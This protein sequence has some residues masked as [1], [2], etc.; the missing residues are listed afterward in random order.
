V[1]SGTPGPVVAKLNAEIVRL[2]K[3]QEVSERL[4]AVQAADPHGTTPGEFQRFVESEYARWGR[5]VKEAK[6]SIPQ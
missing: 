2:L 3:V 1:P 4:V 5:L 6:I